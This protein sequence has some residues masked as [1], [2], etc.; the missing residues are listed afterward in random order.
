MTKFNPENKESLTYGECLD[1]AMKI[2]DQHDADQYLYDYVRFIEK[3]IDPTSNMTAIQMAK[4]N[5][6]YYAGYH[7]DDTRLRVETLF[8]CKHPIFGSIAEKDSLTSEEAFNLGMKIG[9]NE[10]EK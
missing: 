8:M 1:P 6:G 2:T 4:Y 5:L 10:I 7:N 9:L 3:N